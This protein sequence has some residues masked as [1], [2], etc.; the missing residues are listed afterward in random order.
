MIILSSSGWAFYPG[1]HKNC[2]QNV[3]GFRVPL[4][5]RKASIRVVTFITILDV[6]FLDGL[7][8]LLS[9]AREDCSIS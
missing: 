1:A 8:I 5:I 6:L 7:Q 4:V 3:Y 9:R 2:S